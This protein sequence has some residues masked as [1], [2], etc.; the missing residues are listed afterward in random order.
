M[1]PIPPHEHLVETRKCRQCEADFP[2]TDKDIEFYSK[3]SPTFGGQKYPIPSPTLCP[4]CRA[5]RRLAWRNERKLYKRKCDATGKDIVSVYSPASPFTVYEQDYWWSDKWDP[6]DYGREFDFTRSAFEQFRELLRVVPRPSLFNTN[7]ENSEYTQTCT[8]NKNTYMLFESSFDEDCLYGYWL[9]HADFCVDCS[10]CDRTHQCYECLDCRD[11]HALFFSQDCQDCLESMYLR[12]CIGCSDC[13]GCQN[14][15]NQKYHFFNVEYPEAEYRKKVEDFLKEYPTKIERDSI[16]SAF[17]QKGI[18]RASRIDQSEDCSGDSIRHGKNCHSCFYIFDHAENAKY[19]CNTWLNALSVMDG[20]AVG[21]S[22]SYIYES[23][24]TA[25]ESS[26]DMFCV[27]CWGTR[28]GMYLNE[29]DNV[30]NCFLSVWLERKSYCILNRQYTKEEYE[31]LVP[32]IIEKMMATPLRG[33]FEGQVEWGEFFPAS[34]SPFGYNETV[35]NEYF[36]LSRGDVLGNSPL[37]KGDVTKWQGDLVSEKLQKQN[38]PNPLYQGG[39]SKED[40]LHWTTFNWSD[41]EAPFPKVEKI[42][43]ASKLPD[44]IRKIPDDI[45]NWAIEC[46]VSGKPFRIIK[47]ELEFYRKHSLPIPRR[48]PDVRHMDRMKMRNPRK[49]FEGLCDCERCEENW[50]KKTETHINQ[51]LSFSEGG[52]LPASKRFSQ[53][54]NDKKEKSDAKELFALNP[55]TGKLAKKMITT[56]APERPEKIYCEVC[57]EKEVSK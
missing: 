29:C 5:Q 55:K 20:D 26:N 32:R 51:N 4:G 34:M 50:R 13:F 25:L 14:L 42:I 7:S 8:D 46:E 57:Y 43:P 3:L 6:M 38:P 48:H 28:Y 49:L 33:G 53:S 56:Y 1:Y 54:E 35:A 10:F 36:S 24:N 39:I 9:H 40:F 12:D 2:I 19:M 31:E 23:I 18:Q 44:D 15:R 21:A 47:Q 11:C 41:Y 52:S 22:G 30:S 17:F 16:V 45:L 27:R 37:R